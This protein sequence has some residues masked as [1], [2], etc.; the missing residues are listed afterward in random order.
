MIPSNE[1]ES[2]VSGRQSTFGT[3]DGNIFTETRTNLLIKVNLLRNRVSIIYYNIIIYKYF[4][5]VCFYSFISP[6]CRLLYNFLTNSIS[7][8]I[9]R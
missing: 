5:A 2:C 7:R 6:V 3:E 9:S 4:N 8:Q 1:E